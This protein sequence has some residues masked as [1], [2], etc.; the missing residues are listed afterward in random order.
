[1]W[2]GDD[3]RIFKK[4]W[5]NIVKIFRMGIMERATLSDSEG[6]TSLKGEI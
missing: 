3:L 1:M 6:K 5:E 4:I 2:R